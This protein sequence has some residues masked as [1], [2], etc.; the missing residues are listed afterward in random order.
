MKTQL[1]CYICG[2]TLNNKFMLVTFKGICTDR[3][4]LVCEKNTCI[5]RVNDSFQILIPV[6]KRKK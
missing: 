4:F 6:L 2:K 5:D 3:V 1:Y